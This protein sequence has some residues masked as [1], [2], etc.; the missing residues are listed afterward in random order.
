MKP[1]EPREA[2]GRVLPK[3]S[4]DGLGGSGGKDGGREQKAPFVEVCPWVLGPK[5][6]IHILPCLPG[7]SLS[8]SAPICQKGITLAQT[9]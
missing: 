9:S 6:R 4:R 3:P 1:R 2:Q 8:L 7:G 5:R